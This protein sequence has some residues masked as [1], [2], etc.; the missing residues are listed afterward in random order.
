MK[1]PAKTGAFKRPFF[2]GCGSKC[3]W[4]FLPKTPRKWHKYSR[5][6]L[7]GYYFFL[8]RSVFPPPHLAQSPTKQNWGFVCDGRS[9]GAPAS[10][11]QIENNCACTVRVMGNFRF[12]TCLDKTR[13]QGKIQLLRIHGILPI[14]HKIPLLR[15]R[16]R[17]SQG[18]ESRHAA[19]G[20]RL[21][22]LRQCNSREY[23]HDE[24]DH[25]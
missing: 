16:H 13:G 19:A 9:P 5:P 2:S 15:L 21:G 18:N 23:A 8:P 20:H 11:A 4:S 10:P 1:Y 6:I 17:R 25:E 24:N 14:G 3:I 12:T 22:I 7:F